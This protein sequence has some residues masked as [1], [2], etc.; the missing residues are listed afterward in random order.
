MYV[1]PTLRPRIRL[2]RHFAY[3]VVEPLGVTRDA[4]GEPVRTSAWLPWRRRI[5][6]GRDQAEQDIL[7]RPIRFPP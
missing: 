4:N 3:S 1:N 2:L 6:P 7:S 5:T